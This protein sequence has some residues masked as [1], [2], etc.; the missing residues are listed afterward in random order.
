MPMQMYLN[1]I[2]KLEKI[3]N[4]CSLVVIITIE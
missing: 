2:G 4:F 1:G 3:E